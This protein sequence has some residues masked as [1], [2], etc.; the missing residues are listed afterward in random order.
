MSTIVVEECSEIG[1]MSQAD[2]ENMALRFEQAT[3]RSR[4]SQGQYSS[5]PQNDQILRQMAAARGH[6]G[7][8][9]PPDL[10][11]SLPVSFDDE[12]D[13]IPTA[14]Q[15]SRRV[16]VAYGCVKESTGRVFAANG[17]LEAARRTLEAARFDVL[18]KHP[19]P[20]ALGSNE[21]ARKAAVAVLV[22]TEADA[23]HAA[24]IDV[25]NANHLLRLHQLEVSAAMAQLRI[26]EL[27]D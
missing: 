14:G 24:Q 25:D 5:G 21:D 20:K 23:V 11:G 3:G 27:W 12:E 18:R 1:G 10:S 15:L 8:D 13:S 19:D 6:D 2:V 22:A 4:R 16:E 7:A 26:A 9:S 17:V